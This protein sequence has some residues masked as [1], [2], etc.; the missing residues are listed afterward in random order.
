MSNGYA[1]FNILISSKFF[2]KDE[3]GSLLIGPI[4][5]T[6]LDRDGKQ[7]FAF[8]IAEID[9][10]HL[11]AAASRFYIALGTEDE[12]LERERSMS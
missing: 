6:F 1:D 8:E 7:W 9:G 10:V 2:G 3:D 11:I 5:A 12:L 4:L